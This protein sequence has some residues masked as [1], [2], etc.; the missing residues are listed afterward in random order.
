VVRNLRNS[1]DL[2]LP[3]A[4]NLVVR[5]KGGYAARVPRE[6]VDATHFRQ[7]IADADRLDKTQQDESGAAELYG[8]ALS[9]WD[10]DPAALAEP[11][12][13]LRGTWAEGVR[14]GLKSGRLN[15]VSNWAGIKLRTGN[16]DDTLPV[17]AQLVVLE[18]FDERIAELYMLALCRAGRPAD[19]LSSYR[20][21]RARLSEE[22]GR[23][24]S[25]RIERLHQ[26]IL[27]GDSDLE[28]S[29]ADPGRTRKGKK[30]RDARD[31][32]HGRT[33]QIVNNNKGPITGGIVN[34]GV[35]IGGD[36]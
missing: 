24:P 31:A 19:A 33:P 21:L 3:G 6:Q 25:E 28:P 22:Q 8:Q 27:A 29:M 4:K 26:R 10:N 1:L 36:E 2:T 23:D 16:G 7:L 20:S 11:L 32:R 17:L 5:E 14:Q 15:A 9:L 34:F 13:N 18:R 35:L 12:A 30:R